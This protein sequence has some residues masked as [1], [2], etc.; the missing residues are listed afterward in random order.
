MNKSS[1][2][3]SAG[4]SSAQPPAAS[5]GAAQE[6][7]AQ[8]RF[9]DVVATRQSQADDGDVE[10]KLW[11]G[12]YSSRAMFGSAILVAVISA[13]LIVASI[14]FQFPDWR[15]T[16][17]TLLI[18]WLLLATRYMVRRLSIHYELTNQRFIH[19]SGLISRRIDRI[20]VIEIEDVSIFQGPMERLFGI[21][22]IDIT[23]NDRSHPHLVMPGIADV[24]RVASMID[25]V[26]RR[27]RK[28]RSLHIRS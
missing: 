7:T 16:L 1:Q 24:R 10:K 8:Q 4:E 6:A 26:R 17:L 25:D 23:S 14:A 5:S 20:E 28:R 21:G 9:R 19:Q 27:E 18:I 2:T 11:E 12:N 13:A 3:P 15:L 22:T